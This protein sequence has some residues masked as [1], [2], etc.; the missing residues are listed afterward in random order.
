MSPLVVYG[1]SHAEQHGIDS[2]HEPHLHWALKEFYTQ[3]GGSMP[4]Y[5]L[6]VPN[7]WSMEKVV[8]RTNDEGLKGLLS[9]AGG[10]ITLA[11]VMRDPYSPS[12]GSGFLDSD[13]EAAVL[14]SKALLMEQQEKNQPLRLLIEGRISDEDSPMVFSPKEAGNGFCGVVLGE[15]DTMSRASVGLALGRA[16][17]YPAHVKL[18]N[19]QNGP[20]YPANM[21]IGT[22]RVDQLENAEQLHDKG[23]ITFMKRP[24]SG[25]YYFGRD[26]MCAQDDYYILAHGRIMDKAQRIAAAAAVPYLET[27]VRLDADGSINDIDAKAIEDTIQQALATGLGGQVSRIRVFVDPAQME[28]VRASSL[29]VS[30]SIQPLGYLTYITITIGLASTI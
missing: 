25:G 4:L 13:V 2:V 8:D 1:L 5:V 28:P 30:I 20:L 9:F 21:Y 29:R 23:Y 15:S 17:Q 22:K 7:S 3:L 18:G 11:G 14:K 6:G 12:L 24:G 26:Y 19:G 27:D 16:C 10:A